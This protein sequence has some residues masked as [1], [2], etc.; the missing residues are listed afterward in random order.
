MHIVEPEV[1]GRHGVTPPDEQLQITV[2]G[3]LNSLFPGADDIETKFTLKIECRRIPHADNFYGVKLLCFAEFSNNCVELRVRP[4]GNVHSWQC[5]L[6]CPNKEWAQRLHNVTRPA[7]IAYS[8]Y[9]VHIT[10]E[11]TKFRVDDYTQGISKNEKEKLRNGFVRLIRDIERRETK[12]R[13][14]YNLRQVVATEDV[15]ISVLR[16]EIALTLNIKETLDKIL[17]MGFILELVNKGLLEPVGLSEVQLFHR[18]L[19]FD[20]YADAHEDIL[21][22]KKRDE[23]QGQLNNLTKLRESRQNELTRL[24]KQVENLELTLAEMSSQIR[25]VEYELLQFE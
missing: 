18:T 3:W 22:Q 11:T 19:L 14:C 21:K 15:P 9:C 20:E 13:L 12:Q 6:V 24:Q 5:F 7:T 17:F 1:Q 2:T 23:L 10:N 25:N 8:N 4:N 16:R